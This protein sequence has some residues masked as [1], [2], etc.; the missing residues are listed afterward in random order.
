MTNANVRDFFV[1][2]GL[3]PLRVCIARDTVAYVQVSART[4]HKETSRAILRM[5]NARLNGAEANVNLDDTAFRRV[6]VT[7]IAADVDGAA[8]GELFA[9]LRATDVTIVIGDDAKK[10]NDANDDGDGDVDVV[11][12]DVRDKLKVNCDAAIAM[13]QTATLTMQRRR[14]KSRHF[15]RSPSCNLS[16][17][18]RRPW[19]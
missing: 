12:D 13:S 6:R 5:R 2:H 10:K 11:A 8:I 16:R 17:R 15:Y 19:H 9:P 1:T 3:R 7:G 18:R 14:K 4:E